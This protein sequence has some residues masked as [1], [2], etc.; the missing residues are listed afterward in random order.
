MFNKIHKKYQIFFLIHFRIIFFSFLKKA[1]MTQDIAT[2][3][4]EKKK[5]K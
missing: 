3:K 5:R 2:V 4:N 1:S